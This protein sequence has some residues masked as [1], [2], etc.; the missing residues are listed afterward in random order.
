MHRK[1]RGKKIRLVIAVF[2]ALA[3]GAVFAALSSSA[4]SPLSSALSIVFTP[5][6]KVSAVI[7]NKLSDISADFRSAAVYRDQVAELESEVA[8]YREQLV[9][10]GK[11]KQKMDSYEAFLEI[12]EENPDFKFC[13]AS[14]V[15]RDS[16]DVTDS[17]V[18]DK[19][20]DD[21]IK[22]DQPVIYGSYLVGVVREVNAGSCVVYTILNPK[23]NVGA[24][25]LS[26]REEG[27]I[28]TDT[29][30]AAQSQ[31]KLSPL[32]PK[33]S[34]A[35]GGIICTSGVGGIYPPDL[36]IGTVT[37]VDRDASNVSSYALLSPG[38]DIAALTDVFIITQF[39][40]QGEY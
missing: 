18:L 32:A 3:A 38:V 30:L 37:R 12:K 40:G 5:L 11:M 17:F 22:L 31:M 15:S 27:F 1:F 16:A 10:Y 19:G 33:T 6:Q 20:S 23:V 14:V 26:T 13:P 7:S 24:Y 34:V 29:S 9:D 35:A 36:I 25:E 2:V 8:D 21:G 4:S 39:D 28:S